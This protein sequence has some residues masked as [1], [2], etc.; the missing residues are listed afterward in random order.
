MQVRGP[1]A[2][3]LVA[4]A[5]IGE[6]PPMRAQLREA[7]L[8][9]MQE[10]GGQSEE[11]L[12]H[13]R[14]MLAL[15]ARP[16]VQPPSVFDRDHY[17]PGHF[18]ASGFVLNP[19][20]THLLL[21]RHRKLHMWLQ[22][23]GH[24][25]PADEDWVRAALREVEE[26]TGVS[27]VEVLDSLFDVDV[28]AIP[29]FAQTPAHLHHDVRVLLRTRTSAWTRGEDVDDVRWFPMDQLARGSGELAEG[30]S[31]DSSVRRVARLCLDLS[32]LAC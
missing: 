13:G 23:G 2:L 14:A 15:L 24:I 22:P 9:H 32:G 28:H 12:G 7:L 10:R 8:R 27:D 11:V 29:E 1:Y 31:T 6:K 17:V 18:T 25:E 19:E 21:I 16:A 20:N 5:S 30:L 4:R 26:E 3:S